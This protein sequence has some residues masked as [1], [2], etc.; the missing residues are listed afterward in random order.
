M[1]SWESTTL[2]DV[3]RWSGRYGPYIAL[4][5]V[6]ALVVGVAPGQTS[7]ASSAQGSISTDFTGGEAGGVDEDGAAAAPGAEGAPGEQVTLP[8]GSVDVSAGGGGADGA[9][10]GS[11][12]AG[13]STE[14]GPAPVIAP[15]GGVGSGPPKNCDPKTGR[16][17]MPSVNALAC[18]PGFDGDNG[19]ATYRGVTKDSIKVVVYLAK[20]DATAQAIARAGGSDDSPAQIRQQYKEWVELWQANVETYGRKVVLEFVDGSGAATDDSAARADALRVINSGAFASINAP[21]STYISE[22][23]AK[24]VMCIACGLSLPAES[25]LKWAPYV[26]SISSASTWT[27]LHNVEFAA[28]YLWAKK[29]QYAGDPAFQQSRRKLGRIS[30]DTKDGS[31]KA[32]RDYYNKEMKRR[33]MS[34]AV[35]AVYDGTNT[36]GIQ[37]QARP[38]I[39]KMKAEG[40]TTVIFAGDP[41]A[42]VFFTQEAT[43]QQYFP[44]WVATGTLVDVSFFGRLY[45]QQQWSHM[46]SVSPIAARLPEEMAEPYRLLEWFYGRPPTAQGQYATMRHGPAMLF[47]GIHHAGEKL[48]PQTYAAG[49]FNLQPR[50]GG[51]TFSAV[52]YGTK[53]WPMPDYTGVDDVDFIW[54]DA[55]AR[56]KDEIGNEGVG[57]YRYVNGGQRYMPKDY[58][59]SVNW[60]DPKGTVTVYDDYPPGERPPSYPPPKR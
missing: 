40:V 14:G 7:G 29:A 25:Y 53:V 35:E 28:K 5:S 55:T 32:A 31:F 34:I 50:K 3:A 20:P 54:W 56:G 47:A 36:A 26:W 49:Q 21:N 16:L 24:G 51:K 17:K 11:A 52:S 60:F 2:G 59:A 10:T 39:Q 12:P 33:G 58:P 41:F 18:V 42:P 22:L 43:R 38:I 48:T 46:F 57:L 45:D 19:G 6:V 8:D 1:R 13:E 30:Y 23:A 9:G 44:E 37:Q 27:N 15:P 4:V